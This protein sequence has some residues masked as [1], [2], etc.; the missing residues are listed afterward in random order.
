MGMKA[1]SIDL[2]QKLLHACDQRLGSHRTIATRFGVSLSVV[3]K[4]LRRRRAT[5]AISPR[6][7][8]GG[9]RAIG[10]ATA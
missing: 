7:H 4:W 2:R 5:G 6:P 10:D 3:E 8:A 1:Y 9:R